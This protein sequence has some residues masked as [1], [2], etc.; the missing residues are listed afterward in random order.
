MNV[1]CEGR[2][3]SYKCILIV[4]QERHP[5]LII[6]GRKIF[7]KKRFFNEIFIEIIIKFSIDFSRACNSLITFG[8]LIDYNIINGSI[9]TLSNRSLKPE[10]WLSSILFMYFNIDSQNLTLKSKFNNFIKKNKSVLDI[11]IFKEKWHELVWMYSI[12]F[13]IISYLDYFFQKCYSK[14]KNVKLFIGK[15]SNQEKKQYHHFFFLVNKYV[16]WNLHHHLACHKK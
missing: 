15:S 14:A 5:N 11:I 3:Y 16:A 12:S 6:I 8:V 13:V 9:Y 4:S 1:T 7:I 2:I 10:E